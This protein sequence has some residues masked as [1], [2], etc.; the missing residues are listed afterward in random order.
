MN[1]QLVNFNF[2]DREVALFKDAKTNIETIE[3]NI[4]NIIE[5]NTV[6]EKKKLEEAIQNYNGKIKSILESDN[7]KQQTNKLEEYENVMTQ[8]ISK[9][10]ETYKKA[11]VI[12]DKQE[13][14]TPEKKQEYKILLHRKIIEKFLDQNE[15]Q[16]FNQ[17]I[18]MM[19]NGNVIF[20]GNNPINRCI[21]N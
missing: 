14:L 9:A 6:Q 8:S 18:N 1:N 12:I 15:V 11:L 5:Q 2:L 7:I 13:K 20:V 19:G 17:L 4:N 21:S 3:T 16:M 10:Y